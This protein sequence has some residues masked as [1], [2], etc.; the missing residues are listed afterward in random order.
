[1]AQRRRRPLPDPDDVLA[2][3]LAIGVEDLFELIHAINP[4]GRELA[5]RAEREAYER[6]SG[7][8]SLLIERFGEQLTIAIVAGETD[9]VVAIRHRTYGR[10]ACHA[11]RSKLSPRARA[12]IQRRLDE[13]GEPEAPA[14][15]AARVD[16]DATA[17]AHAGSDVEAA[18]AALDEYDYDR[19]ERLLCG[20]LRT[21]N[22][23]AERRRLVRALLELY[24][25]HLADDARALALRA[26]L[27]SGSEPDPESVCL[28]AIAAARSGDARSARALVADV[29]HT[30]VDRVWIEIARV[31]LAA[32]DF[33]ECVRLLERVPPSSDSAIARQSLA[34]EV[35]R[36][37][38]VASRQLEPQLVDPAITAD[39]VR[40]EALARRIL[41]L[42]PGSEPA[43]EALRALRRSAE[44]RQLAEL[45]AAIDDAVAHG[46]PERARALLLELRASAPDHPLAEIEARVATAERDAAERSATLA[47][48]ALT[49]ALAGP[50]DA[51][52]IRAW[53]E[54]TDAVRALSRAEL[55][56]LPDHERALA[57]LDWIEAFGPT[58]GHARCEATASAVV[59]LADAEQSVARGDPDAARELLE[60]VAEAFPRVPRVERLL[61]EVRIACD[62]RRHELASAAL[63]AAERAAADDAAAALRT[64]TDL[65]VGALDGGERERAKALRASVEEAVELADSRASVDAA[66]ASGDLIE[67]RKALRRVVARAGDQERVRCAAR[68]EEIGRCIESAWIEDRAHGAGVAV[69]DDVHRPFTTYTAVGGD[70]PR[71]VSVTRIGARLFVRVLA[72]IAERSAGVVLR[73]P[74]P[75]D[76]VGIGVDGDRIGLLARE[77]I[78]WLDDATLAV[79]D[80]EPWARSQARTGFAGATLGPDSRFAWLAFDAVGGSCRVRVIDRNGLLPATPELDGIRFQAILGCPDPFVV[81]TRHRNDWQIVDARGNPGIGKRGRRVFHNATLAPGGLGLLVVEGEPRRPEAGGGVEVI[82]QSYRFDGEIGPALV[83]GLTNRPTAEATAATSSTRFDCAFLSLPR[84]GGGTELVAVDASGAELRERWRV[85][86][87]DMHALAQDHSGTEALLQVDDGDAISLVRLTDA[88]PRI[89]LCGVEPEN[90]PDLAA[91]E[92][93]VWRST[94]RLREALAFESVLRLLDGAT[95][96]DRIDA[97]LAA[98]SGPLD[99]LV[100]ISACELPRRAAGRIATVVASAFRG[101]PIA[102]LL[103][104]EHA[105]RHAEHAAALHL[106]EAA[107]VEHGEPGAVQH[108]LHLVAVC[109]LALGRTED[110][111]AVCRRITK[112][113]AGCD[114]VA[115][116]AAWV[117]A[118][119]ASVP[120]DA[121]RLR[122]ASIQSVVLRLRAA[123]RELARGNA[124]SALAFLEH[125]AVWALR[126]PQGSARLAEAWLTLHPRPGP[127]LF[128]AREVLADLLEHHARGETVRGG[129]VRGEIAWDEA[130]LLAVVERAA[131]WLGDA[132]PVACSAHRET[133]EPERPYE[134]PGALVTTSVAPGERPDPLASALEGAEH[135]LRIASHARELTHM[136]AA[137]KGPRPVHQVAG[138]VVDA[139][140]ADVAV[141]R[142]AA[143]RLLDLPQRRSEVVLPVA[144]EALFMLLRAWPRVYE[145]FVRHLDRSVTPD[146]S[147]GVLL[148]RHGAAFG[149]L[150]GDGVRSRDA[151]RGE[152]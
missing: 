21:A 7:L 30:A 9:D 19:A 98:Q 33:D 96:A 22:D 108:H 35:A 63:E 46:R 146:T 99:A 100:A 75:L 24:V 38:E 142:I 78:L 32:G 107:P 124:A 143:E 86:I 50:P 95:I 57:W 43:R 152:P 89:R 133:R 1:M 119:Q 8:Q 4:T 112:Q 26:E 91:R 47:V 70:D 76:V 92:R 84:D 58:K 5:E 137:V 53:G 116:L 94:A 118:T 113:Q 36:H 25:D 18:R 134:P 72:P 45:L 49:L 3:R 90:L 74:V 129:R 62:R 11:L 59:A 148:C 56:A 127:G 16:P 82:A 13:A 23:S 51:N 132:V 60:P 12:W 55:E 106:L 105:V 48:G 40:L 34:E 114:G 10:D 130:R 135:T 136:I 69:D 81:L 28:L 42:H 44:Q 103:A 122:G 61:R 131:Q 6:K 67:A 54:A 88:P 144:Y 41:A 126:D 14:S 80:L 128:R 37:R 15:H 140:H 102:H 123:D 147:I 77:G 52:A 110:A 87:A 64:L 27:S 73:P 111:R 17:P 97:W 79:S 101:E 93:C 150:G 104:A 139:G 65:D 71:M 125:P 141:F 66:L 39:P 145:A 68:I 85:P 83:L 151:S 29:E 115:R 109:L 117:E 121:R 138:L 20:S 31:A 120:S 149:S 2:G